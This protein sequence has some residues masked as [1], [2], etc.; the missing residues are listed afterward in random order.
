MT[1]A[2]DCESFFAAR[3]EAMLC[4]ELIGPA[5]PYTEHD[6]EGVEGAE[7]RVFDVRDRESGAPLPVAERRACCERF[8]LPQVPTFGVH[9]RDDAVAGV[10]EAIEALD[11]RGRECVVLSSLDGERQLKYTTSAIHCSDLEHAFSVPFDDGRA[12]LFSRIVRE[13]FQ[14]VEFGEDEAAVRERAHDLGEAILEPA[15]AAI[16][17][18][19]RGEPVGETH[20]VE[21]D[22]AAIASLLAHFRSQGLEL[23]IERDDRHDGRREVVFTKVASTTRDKTEHYLEGGLIDE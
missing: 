16:R 18:V 13:A 17:Q 14:A 20:T 10:R 23:A 12:F 15:V 6:Y 2:L 4:A 22:P 7:F 19:E 3:P 8:D 5:N 9:D 11:E 1:A 21:D